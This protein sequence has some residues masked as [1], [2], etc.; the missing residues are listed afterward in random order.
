VER[1]KVGLGSGFALR[2]TFEEH[3]MWNVDFVQFARLLDE[4]N[5][6][7]LD[8]KQMKVI[9]SSMNVK[10]QEIKQLLNRATVKWEELNPLL[11]KKTPLTEE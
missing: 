6:V 10:P 4:I 11:K 7:G 8:D 2:V 5:A 1:G 9:S 3:A